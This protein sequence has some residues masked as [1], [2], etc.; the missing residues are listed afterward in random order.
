[1]RFFGYKKILNKHYSETDV[2]CVE[3]NSEIGLGSIELK[4]KNTIYI[5][6]YVIVEVYANEN[7]L[8]ENTK[9]L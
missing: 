2:R 3:F 7:F 5:Y 9:I 1:L 8:S 6:I 4:V